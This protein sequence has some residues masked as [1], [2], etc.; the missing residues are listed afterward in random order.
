MEGIFT[1]E[2]MAR[3][4]GGKHAETSVHI[5]IPLFNIYPPMFSQRVYYTTWEEN[6]F[7]TALP[8]LPA[9]AIFQVEAQDIDKNSLITYS[10]SESSEYFEMSTNGVLVLRKPLDREE[11]HEHIVFARASDGKY[12]STFDAEIRVRVI[13]VNDNSPWFDPVKYYVNVSELFNSLASPITQVHAYDNDTGTAY[14]FSVLNGKI[15]VDSMGYVFLTMSLDYEQASQHNITVNVSDGENESS[16]SAQIIINV[17]DEN[18]HYPFF[19]QSVY[20]GGFPENSPPGTLFI[21]LSASDRDASLMTGTVVR[22]EI[23]EVGLPFYIQTDSS[24]NA[25][26]SNSKSMDYETERRNFVLQIHAFDSGGFRSM[27][28][29]RVSISLEDVDDC[30]PQFSQSVYH[31]NIKE[32]NPIP[33]FITNILASD[34]DISLPFKGIKYTISSRERIVNINPLSGL[35]TAAIVF[36]FESNQNPLVIEV[37]AQSSHNTSQYDTATI[38]L[39]IIDVNEHYP[40]F[41]G[42]PYVAN[43]LESTEVNRPVFRVQAYD[44]DGGDVYGVVSK[45]WILH[46]LSSSPFRLNSSSGELFLTRE[47]DYETGDR[48]FDISVVVVD[49]G[50]YLTRTSIDV[51]I[52]NENDEEPYFI[53]SQEHNVSMKEELFPLNLPGLPENVFLQVR[54][55]DDDIVEGGLLQYNLST[56]ST[57]EIDSNGFLYIT[58]PLDYEDQKEHE[59]EV[60]VN[61]GF[62][63]ARESI[64]VRVIVE[65]VNDHPPIFHGCLD[66][67]CGTDTLIPLQHLIINENSVPAA[68]L[69]VFSACDIDGN[70]L[71]YFIVNSTHSGLEVRGNELHLARPLDHE[72]LS[73]V[74]IFVGCSDGMYNSTNF[75]P[76][77]LLVTDVDDNILAFET[78]YY[79]VSVAEA[80]NPGELIV[81]IRAIDRD[82]PTLDILYTISVDGDDHLPF[83][84]VESDGEAAVTNMESLDYE[85]GNNVYIFNITAEPSGSTTQEEPAMTKIN[86]TVLDVNEYSPEFSSLLYTSNFPENVVGILANV[87]AQDRDSGNVFGEVSYRIVHNPT[88]PCNIS[89]TGEVINQFPLDADV[90]NPVHHILVEAIDGGGL[91]TTTEVVIE[92]QDQNDNGPF[93]S[94]SIYTI[95]VPENIP[96]NTTLLAMKAQDLDYSLRFNTITN[97]EIVSTPFYIPFAISSEGILSVNGMLDFEMQPLYSL[98]ISAVDSGGLTS[99]SPAIVNVN[100]ENTPDEPPVFLSISYVATVAENAAIGTVVAH[101]HAHSIDGG[102]LQYSIRSPNNKLPFEIQAFSGVITVNGSIDYENEQSYDLIIAC[103]VSSNPSVYSTANISVTVTNV[104]DNSPTMM[105]ASYHASVIENAPHRSLELQISASDLDAGVPGIILNFQL[106]SSFTGFFVR[107]FDS[108]GT[109]II[110]NYKSFD[111]EAQESIVF[112][113]IAIDRGRPSRVSHPATIHIH[114]L[115][116]NDNSPRFSQNVY[117]IAIPEGTTGH[118]YTVIATDRDKGVLSGTVVNYQLI[119]STVPFY[120]TENGSIFASDILDYDGF[121]LYDSPLYEFSVVAFDAFG[122]SS[123]PAQVIVNILN[124]NDNAPTPKYES[125][126]PIKYVQIEWGTSVSLVPIASLSAVDRDRDDSLYYQL[127]YTNRLQSSPLSLIHMGSGDII[128]QRPLTTLTAYNLTV[129]IQDRHPLLHSPE[130]RTLQWTVFAAVVDTN[131]PPYFSPDQLTH[132]I[133]IQEGEASDDSLLQILAI[134]DD[135]PGSI[136]AEIVSYN[137]LSLNH[138]LSIPFTFTTSGKLK[139]TDRLSVGNFTSFEFEVVAKDGGGLMTPDPVS[140]TIRVEESNDFAPVLFVHEYHYTVYDNAPPG[141]HILSVTVTDEDEGVSGVFVCSFLEDIELFEISPNSC[142]VSLKSEL[143]YSSLITTNYSVTI[144]ASDYGTP[145][146]SDSVTIHILVVPAIIQELELSVNRTQISYTEEQGPVLVLQDFN[147][148]QGTHNRPKYVAEIGLAPAAMLTPDE[149]STQCSTGGNAVY[150]PDCFPGFTLCLPAFDDSIIT[151]SQETLHPVLSMDVAPDT[152]VVSFQSW[153]KVGQ[154]VS[155]PTVILSGYSTATDF[156]NNLFYLSISRISVAVKVGSVLNSERIELSINT[157]HHIIVTMTPS[158]V[159]LYIDGQRPIMFGGSQLNLLGTLNIYIGRLKVGNYLRPFIGSMLGPSISLSSVKREEISRYLFCAMSCGE[160]IFSDRLDDNVEFYVVPNRLIMITENFQ[161]ISNALLGL[162]YNNTASEPTTQLKNITVMLTDGKYETDAVVILRTILVNEH[163]AFMDLRVETSGNVFFYVEPSLGPY[164]TKTT[165]SA[166]FTDEDTT[167]TDYGLRVDIVPPPRRRLCDRLDYAVKV[168]LEQCGRSPPLVMNL[169]PDYQWGLGRV[170]GV[171]SFYDYFLGYR[172]YGSGLFIP[173]MGIYQNLNM[174][175]FHFTFV[176]WLKLDGMGTVAHVVDSVHPYLFWLRVNSTMLQTVLSFHAEQQVSLYWNWGQS[177]EWVHVAVIVDAP[178][179]KVCINGYDCQIQ[180]LPLHPTQHVFLNHLDTHVGA[181]PDNDAYTDN[182]DGTLSGVVLIPNYTMPLTTL[183]CLISCAEYIVI[184]NFESYTGSP[185]PSLTTTGIVSINGSLLV[186]ADVT[187]NTMQDFLQ[188]VAYINTHPYP[189]PG[190]RQL[191]YSVREE[192]SDRDLVGT[193][194]VVVLYHGYRNLQLLR[195]LRVTITA[196]QLVYGVRP[197]ESTGITTDARTNKMDS[198]VIELT[199][200]PHRSSRCLTSSSAQ[201][202]CPYLLHLN[203]NLLHNSTLHI[204]RKSHKIIVCGLSTVNHYQTLLREVRVQWANPSD[205]VTSRSEFKLRVYISD[206]NGISFTTKTLTVQVQGIVSPQED[207]SDIGSDRGH[208]NN[209]TSTEHSESTNILETE[210]S[211]ASSMYPVYLFVC[212]LFVVTI[213]L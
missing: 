60:S 149:F 18:D 134:D 61:D 140:I 141:E 207:D 93:F 22:Y 212:F 139:Q 113:V 59:L 26:L 68:P 155:E 186:D 177:N 200:R 25:V 159:Q 115:D 51:M 3:D 63:T 9:N 21:P 173:D 53:G 111:F 17:I 43:I 20:R 166:V 162:S 181:L 106:L 38:I 40:E 105:Q 16:Q 170:I 31:A 128:L 137:I 210:F 154:N 81:P 187:Q 179:I 88:L 75:V 190:E 135:Y 92:V 204:I 198:L 55:L 195:I 100:I 189:H 27:F 193:S 99:S 167:Q 97:Y 122:V 126:W 158:S 143:N 11:S 209:L 76:V 121:S 117:S 131:S 89:K 165:P 66:G 178:E 34:C 15:S 196:T 70:V 123:E 174:N 132:I 29:T 80:I 203:Q 77:E 108:N 95:N 133:T 39:S 119:P 54:A 185:L 142:D 65:N 110:S 172:F 86:I 47:L 41:V 169:L 98:T 23:Q 74:H 102:E 127:T 130:A 157:W 52:I 136:F 208:T 13:D 58:A 35:V 168:K 152:E 83:N 138:S 176:A 183:N 5:S 14:Q 175:M 182:F 118:V 79:E 144:V 72:E 62:Y 32:N 148:L 82:L 48:R 120:V 1:F 24:G 145:S 42:L 33:V 150:L 96:I 57:F 71:Q 147:L 153:I 171:Q 7:N 36:D 78:E 87:S 4:K 129:T 56:D 109:A 197:F 28:P 180:T 44:E 163:L 104:N 125:E 49:G 46:D 202:D 164:P 188:N 112:S 151:F 69:L 50:S 146:L 184:N 201:S 67:C 12:N 114:I 156:D 124:E 199:S 84:I 90:D 85:S 2:V 194:S 205:V 19:P 101:V 45:Y 30:G 94:S 213:T 64:F 192:S 116:A 103:Q 10:L 91:S 37:R 107:E 211:G 206:T 191:L 6:L 73:I 160:T 161:S 8:G